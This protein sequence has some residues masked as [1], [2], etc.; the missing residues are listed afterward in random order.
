MTVVQDDQPGF[1]GL[2]A[3]QTFLIISELKLSDLNDQEPHLNSY[4]PNTFNLNN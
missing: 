2:Y 3:V 4:A 1:S